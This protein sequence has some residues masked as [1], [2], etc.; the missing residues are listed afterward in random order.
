MYLSVPGQ[1]LFY[2][3][4]VLFLV[5]VD[6]KSD[7]SKHTIGFVA[8]AQAAKNCK[9]QCRHIMGYKTKR[10]NEL[11][12]CGKEL[13]KILNFEAADNEVLLAQV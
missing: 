3:V 9:K 10:K 5:S 1:L 6:I 7:D 13:T 4:A 2:I 8:E 11:R 12:K